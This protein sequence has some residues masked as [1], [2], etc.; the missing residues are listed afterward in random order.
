MI[1]FSSTYKPNIEQN[2]PY[3]HTSYSKASAL[4]IEEFNPVSSIL[5]TLSMRPSLKPRHLKPIGPTPSP[6]F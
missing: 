6:F 2:H 5:S 4:S 1:S 3:Q